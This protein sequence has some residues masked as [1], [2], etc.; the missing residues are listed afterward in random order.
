MVN[1]LLGL[2]RVAKCSGCHRSRNARADADATRK[3]SKKVTGEIVEVELEHLIKQPGPR[4]TGS[5]FI[6]MQ[7]WTL[8][9]AMNRLTTIKK[10]NIFRI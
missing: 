5:I 8:K 9:K 6:I 7:H 4:D 3:V 2:I 1:H 10:R